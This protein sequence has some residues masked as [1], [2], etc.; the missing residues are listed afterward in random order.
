[1]S[2]QINI[3]TNKQRQSGFTLVEIMVT[4][5]VMTIGFLGLAGLQATALRSNSGATL[6]T[7]AVIYANDM[8]ERIRA[9]PLAVADNVVP[10]PNHQFQNVGPL[11][12]VDCNALPVT[13]IC[14]EFWDD[15]INAIVPAG[16]CN[17]SQLALWDINTWFCGVPRDG[18]DPTIRGEGI[19]SQLPQASATILCNDNNGADVD[20]CSPNSTHTITVTWRTIKEKGTNFIDT[21]ECLNTNDIATDCQSISLVIQP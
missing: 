1:M 4:M 8:A 6:R 19:N 20:P 18:G 10:V 15:G 21:G 12:N 11:G 14:E 17:A 7:Q 3:H 9:N 2:N 13:P 5:V 16:L